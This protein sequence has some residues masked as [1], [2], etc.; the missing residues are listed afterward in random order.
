LRADV[1]SYSVKPLSEV[2]MTAYRKLSASVIC[3]LLSAVISC[4]G[5][6]KTPNP[7]GGPPP[8]FQN[9][10]TNDEIINACTTDDV[11]KID[12]HPVL[13]LANPDGTLPPLP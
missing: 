2:K 7:D 4:A 8:C 9:P 6:H 10:Q 3:A 13:P 5:G 12:K 1:L 11:V